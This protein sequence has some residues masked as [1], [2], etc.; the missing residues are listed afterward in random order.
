MQITVAAQE[1]FEKENLYNTYFADGKLR[2]KKI[3]LVV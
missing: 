1:P 3:K 2:Q